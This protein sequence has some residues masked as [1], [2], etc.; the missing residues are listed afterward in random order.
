MVCSG[1]KPILYQVEVT[2]ISLNGFAER[3]IV[4]EMRDGKVGEI[5][6]YNMLSDREIR[7]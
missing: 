3:N 7:R 6:Y 2:F 4:R 5:R 1:S